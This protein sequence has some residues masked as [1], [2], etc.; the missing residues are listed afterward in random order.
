MIQITETVKHSAPAQLAQQVI[1]GQQA[2]EG[3]GVECRK[4]WFRNPSAVLTEA[5]GGVAVDG[6]V[7]QE[8][9]AELP[10]VGAQAVLERVARERV[11][12]HHVPL[13][14]ERARLLLAAR[15]RGARL[16]EAHAEH[17]QEPTSTA[18]AAS[19]V[20]RHVTS[21]HVGQRDALP[22]RNLSNKK[23]TRRA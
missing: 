11:P 15:A 10:R 16:G 5:V 14:R 17:V 2:S 7:V 21:R 12:D 4:V 18:R 9:H 13:V 20:H 22:S 1:A 23:R 8:A 3:Q 19:R 6:R